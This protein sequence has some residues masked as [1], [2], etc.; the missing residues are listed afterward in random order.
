MR[1]FVPVFL[2]LIKWSQIYD[3]R[4]TWGHLEKN[5]PLI[6]FNSLDAL[7]ISACLRVANTIQNETF[8]TDIADYVLT[9]KMISA[10]DFSFVHQLG[11]NT[12]NDIIQ[13]G[14]FTEKER[15]LLL[16]AWFDTRTNRMGSPAIF[17]A[18]V[19]RLIDQI[20]CTNFDSKF[21]TGLLCKADSYFSN[22]QICK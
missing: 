6:R 20:D 13:Y 1:F 15:L 14:P 22:N 9:N 18:A 21:I 3:E 19:E 17:E 2:Y 12:M 7:D 11:D 8:S 5:L 10:E 16:I 4:L